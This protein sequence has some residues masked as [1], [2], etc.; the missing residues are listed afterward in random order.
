MKQILEVFTSGLDEIKAGQEEMKL[1]MSQEKKARQQEMK[2][3]VLVE[4]KN[5]VK[6]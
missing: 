2:K 3:D 1:I 5:R 4:M 6:I